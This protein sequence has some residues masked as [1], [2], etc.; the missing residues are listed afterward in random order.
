[1]DDITGLKTPPQD[2]SAGVE[3]RPAGYFVSSGVH[4]VPGP[5]GLSGHR[6]QPAVAAQGSGGGFMHMWTI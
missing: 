5:G 4:Q 3:H 6:L 1:M 2:S